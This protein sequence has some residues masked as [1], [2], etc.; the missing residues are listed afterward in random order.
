MSKACLICTNQFQGI[1]II[2]LECDKKIKTQGA[3]PA[4]WKE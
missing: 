3:I 2:C 4:D 1:D